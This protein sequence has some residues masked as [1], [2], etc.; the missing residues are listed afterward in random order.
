MLMAFGY[1]WN[2]L[3]WGAALWWLQG[4]FQ[5]QLSHNLK[6]REKGFVPFVSRHVQVL[7]SLQAHNR[8]PILFLL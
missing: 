4:P 2:S 3:G 7:A 1:D 8:R 5:A 6:G